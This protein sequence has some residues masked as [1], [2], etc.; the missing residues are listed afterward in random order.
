MKEFRSPVMHIE[1][2]DRKRPGLRHHD[3][4]DASPAPR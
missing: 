4:P 1:R 3:T 2:L